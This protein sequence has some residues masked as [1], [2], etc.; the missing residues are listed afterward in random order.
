M[1]NKEISDIISKMSSQEILSLIKK[2]LTGNLPEEFSLTPT[3]YDP[4]NYENVSY[5]VMQS[6][7]AGKSIKRFA[8]SVQDKLRDNLRGNSKEESE[9]LINNLPTG[10]TEAQVNLLLGSY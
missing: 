4:G 6:L 10:I 5:G 9:E 2:S 7:G 3:M 1:N 8:I